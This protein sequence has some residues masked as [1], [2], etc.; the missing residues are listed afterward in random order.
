MYSETCDEDADPR[1]GQPPLLDAG[2]YATIVFT[3][4]NGEPFE[5]ED[6]KLSVACDHPLVHFLP[7][8]QYLIGDM[9]AQTGTGWPFSVTVRAYAEPGVAFGETAT[10]TFSFEARGF[11]VK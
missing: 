1:F 8:R 7:E 11:V 9:P 6:L 2:E 4:R 10:F 3:M 5:L